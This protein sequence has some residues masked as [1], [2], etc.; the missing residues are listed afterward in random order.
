MDEEQKGEFRWLD[1]T[2]LAPPHFVNWQ[3]GKPAND[4]QK[5]G[6]HWVG[7]TAEADSGGQVTGKW[8]DHDDA[9]LFFVCEWER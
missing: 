4:G 5:N 8:S 6:G 9:N 3:K 7:V 2:P 1:G